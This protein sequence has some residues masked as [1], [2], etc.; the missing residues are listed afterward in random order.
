[1]RHL[2]DSHGGFTVRL[3]TGAL[4]PCGISVATRPSRA[5]SFPRESWCDERVT[6]WV[7]GLSDGPAWRCGAVGGWID[8]TSQMVW[9]DVVRVVPAALRWPAC[10]LGRVM[11]QHC[12][13]D[14]GRRETLVLR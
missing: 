3:R 7:A 6:E 13:F 12:V 4:V 5:L 2:I 14:L 11:R 9:L 10:M 1:M 8:P